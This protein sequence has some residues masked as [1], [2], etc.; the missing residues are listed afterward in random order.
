MGH[1]LT[2]DA[3]FFCAH[4]L[5]CAECVQVFRT[6]PAQS[7]GS[8]ISLRQTNCKYGSFS[9]LAFHIDFSIHEFHQLLCYAHA[10]SDAFYLTVGIQVES[11]IFIIQNLYLLRRHT[12]SGVAYQYYKHHLRPG[13]FSGNL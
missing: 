1:L 2:F 11:R 9:S 3:G 8:D 10:Q 5:S 6:L 4:T 7:G 13:I 12:L